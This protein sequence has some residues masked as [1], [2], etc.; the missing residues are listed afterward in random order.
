M[1]K[2]R[3]RGNSG[4]NEA[5]SLQE[6]ATICTGSTWRPGDIRFFCALMDAVKLAEPGMARITGSY[7]TRYIAGEVEQITSK[8]SCGHAASATEPSTPT[9]SRSGRP[10]REPPKRVRRAHWKREIERG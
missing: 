2:R 3:K 9:G 10:K 8:T 4:I 5:L 1:S 7:I 6:A